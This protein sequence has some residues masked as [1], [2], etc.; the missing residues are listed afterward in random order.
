MAQRYLVTAGLPYSN[1]RLH[2]GHIAGAYLP[3]DTYVRFLRATGNDV[4]FICGSD[5]NGV[6]ALKTAREEN[7]SVEELT[8]FYNG[9]QHAD[10]S[11][12]GIEF[13][14][15]GGTHQPDFVQTH[16]RF[17]QEMFLKIH[18][19]GYFTKRRTMQLYDAE[20]KQFLP[21]RYVQGTCPHCGSDQAFGDQC[22]GCGRSLVALDLIDPVSKMTGA[23]AEPRETVHWFLRLDQ[24]ED[25]LRSWIEEKRDR[26]RESVL[27]FVLG[28]MSYAIQAA[29]EIA[30][31]DPLLARLPTHKIRK[32]DEGS[33]L[34]FDS[35]EERD[36]AFNLLREAGKP[37]E[38][39]HGLP[40]RAMTRD[41]SWGVPVPLDDPDAEGK[42]LYVW[43]DAPIGYVSVTGALCD[44]NGEGEEAYADW[45]KDPACRVV[46]FIGEDNTVFHAIIW[47]A[48]LLATHDSDSVQGEKGEY[49]LPYN[50]V[51]NA[52]VN[53]KFPGKDEEKMSKS[54]GTAIWIEEY[55]EQFDPDPLRYYLT[56]I[57]PENARTAFDVDDFITRNNGELLNALGNFFNRTITFAHKYF[58]GRVPASGNRLPEDDDQ[59]KRCAEAADKI[60]A[61]FEACRFRSALGEIMSLAR[62]GNG[63]FDLTK[64]FMS[65][66]T[67]MDACGRA[68]NVCL[69]TAR[70][71]TTVMAPVLPHTAEN[72]ARMLRLGNDW[73]L[74]SNATE[75]LPDGHQLGE[76]EILVKRLDAKEL[77]GEN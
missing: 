37:C 21:D 45:W 11:G 19:K 58:D 17:S 6:A 20:A 75:P 62:D 65:R 68:I 52:F 26:W 55:L 38:I 49:Q 53:I 28:Q 14:I 13:D 47:P 8:A 22:E 70:T 33:R 64:P 46:H 63:Y 59:L 25:T 61:E 5:D 10:F 72:A 18:E 42:V 7:R 9:R 15:Y 40:E 69:Q 48:M 57:A 16:E 31:D 60:A 74:W 51:A 23:K 1:G 12:L 66:K 44:R 36:Q 32:E 27:K 34:Q 43:F 76:A 54:R 39:V 50:V 29:A 77:F 71:L 35:K 56:A 67:D 73:S 4:R 3:A 41:L 2:V 24:L 30:P